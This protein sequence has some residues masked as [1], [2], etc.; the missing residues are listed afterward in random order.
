VWERIQAVR[1][2]GLHSSAP[3]HQK[4]YAELPLGLFYY[5]DASNAERTGPFETNTDVYYTIAGD[6]ADFL[7][8]GDAGKLD[9]RR[10]L[11]KLRMPVLVVAGRFDRVVLPRYSEQFQRYIPSATFHMFEKSGHMPFVEEPEET[12]KVIRAFVGK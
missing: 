4:A 6:D 1:R 11:S 7:I 2:K 3:E 5:Y 8:G 10:E 9:F 12:F